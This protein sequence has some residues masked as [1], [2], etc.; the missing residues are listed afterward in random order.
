[1]ED[2]SRKKKCRKIELADKNLKRFLR[3]HQQEK[4]K[5]RPCEEAHNNNKKGRLNTKRFK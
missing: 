3:K 5:Q 1:M 2:R 4:W